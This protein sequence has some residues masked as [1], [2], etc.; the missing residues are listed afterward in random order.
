[1]KRLTVAAVKVSGSGE[2]VSFTYIPFA[3]GPESASI[4]L[5]ITVPA[6]TGLKAG[7][8]VTVGRVLDFMLGAMQS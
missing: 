2:V 8:T 3:F 5:A 1:M 7:D 4:Q 6:P